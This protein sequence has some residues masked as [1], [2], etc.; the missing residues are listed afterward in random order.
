M[1]KNYR[2]KMLICALLLGST[3]C[4][5]NEE[6]VV[7]KAAISKEKLQQIYDMGFGTSDVKVVEGGYLVEGDILLTDEQLNSQQDAKF[8]RVSETE[9]YRT[10]NLVS[11]GT[12][13]TIKVA[14]STSLPTAYV[15]ALDEAIR[16]YNAENLLI[17][18]QRV[19]S[20]YNI[21]LTKSPSDA[22]YLASAGFPSGGNPYNQVLVNSTYLGSSPGTNYLATILAHE[23]GHCIGF[24][25]TD[26][27]DRSY[28]CGGAYT[29]EGAST[30]GAIHIPGTPTTAD[31]TSW[32]LACVGT[33]QNRPFNSNDRTALNYLY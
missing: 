14:I 25:H 19:S 9:Q 7:E 23:I 11:V 10:T 8:L 3:A 2:I 12:G 32:M 22:P 1:K 16:R 5:L 17:K 26:Y 28:S 33:G 15:T 20:S 30:V 4:S 27:M 24:R 21:L 29:N 18:F 13:R 31:A 6:E